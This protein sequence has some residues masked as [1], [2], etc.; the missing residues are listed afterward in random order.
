[1]L[2]GMSIR[3]ISTGSLHHVSTRSRGS[4]AHRGLAL[5]HFLSR[6]TNSGLSCAAGAEHGR[7]TTATGWVLWR[8]LLLVVI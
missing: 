6:G 2:V 3:A 1:M 5:P 7:T 4:R 8:S